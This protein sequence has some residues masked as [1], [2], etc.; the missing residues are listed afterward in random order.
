MDQAVPARIAPL[1]QFPLPDGRICRQPA[2]AGECICRHHMRNFRHGAQQF[3]H[4]EAMDRYI[5][6]LREM[7]LP[8][9]L[10][11]LSLKLSKIRKAIPRWDEARVTLE[12][13][14][15]ELRRIIT[16]EAPLFD[17]DQPAFDEQFID[18]ELQKLMEQIR[19]LSTH[20]PHEN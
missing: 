18:P 3:A 11:T 9:L 12:F 2:L 6:S 5:D 10:F 14:I 13:V 15:A 16:E 4:E 17:P 8:Q 19:E 20:P 1:C 7:S